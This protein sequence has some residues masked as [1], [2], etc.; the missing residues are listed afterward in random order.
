MALLPN[1]WFAEAFPSAFL[2]RALAFPSASLAKALALLPGPLIAEVFPSGDRAPWGQKW[3]QLLVLQ[4]QAS[5]AAVPEA[6]AAAGLQ[7]SA[8]AVAGLEASAQGV[9]WVVGTMAKDGPAPAPPAA[10]WRAAHEG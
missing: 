8:V 2:S 4:L 6:L 9:P 7:A 5:A 10:V 1:P 3:A